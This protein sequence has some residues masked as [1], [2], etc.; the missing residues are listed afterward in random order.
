MKT[1]VVMVRKMGQFDIFQRTQDGMFNATSLA[2]QW[3]LTNNQKDVSDFLLLKG[4]KEFV[5]TVKQRE[6]DNTIKVVLSKKGKN[7]GTWLHPLVFIDFAMWLNPSFK[8]DVLKFVHDELI[9]KRNDAGDGY[10]KLSAS[11]IKLKG[12]DFVEVAKAIQWIVY[13][14]T[15]KDLRQSSTQEQLQEINDI[16]TKLSFAIDMGFIKSYQQLIFDM[17]KMYRKK[18]LTPPF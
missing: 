16:Q 18:Y 5:E 14:T 10:V 7:G 12:Y 3:S 4:T 1:S 9:K 8:Y 15:G 2:K 6:N 13:D 11:G 17:Q